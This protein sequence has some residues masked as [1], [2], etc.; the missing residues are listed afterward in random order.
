MHKLGAGDVAECID[1]ANERLRLDQEGDD[2]EIV[3]L[4][5]ASSAEEA[6]PLIEKI[7]R[8]YC[9]DSTLDEQL[10]AGK[11]V[12][13]LRQ[14]YLTKSESIESLDEIFTRLYYRLGYPSWLT[15]LS[16]NCEYAADIPAFLVPFEQ[17]FEYIAGLW[18]AAHNRQE[19]DSTYSRQISNQHDLAR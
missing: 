6:M 14:R 10:A 15:M 13:E 12:A 5:G 4:A 8:R 16:R 19:F 18:A 9:G 3:L 17:E 11:C 1:W 2:L 7:L